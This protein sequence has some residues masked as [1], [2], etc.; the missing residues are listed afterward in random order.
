MILNYINYIPETMYYWAVNSKMQTSHTLRLYSRPKRYGALQDC[1][2]LRNLRNSNSKITVPHTTKHIDNN[3]VD[4]P[5]PRGHLEELVDVPRLEQLGQVAEQG[6]QVCAEPRLA[7]LDDRRVQGEEDI[8]GR[9]RRK[10][11]GLSLIHISEPTR[12]Y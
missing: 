9:Q 5:D 8:R 10:G 11:Q 3:L 6:A 2:E 1:R 4:L 7:L 12:P